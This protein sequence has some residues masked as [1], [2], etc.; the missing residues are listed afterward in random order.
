QDERTIY[1]LQDGVHRFRYHAQ[2][3]HLLGC[4]CSVCAKACAS[5]PRSDARALHEPA[6]DRLQFELP[7]FLLASI[8]DFLLALSAHRTP[9]VGVPN[10]PLRH[11]FA[12]L[13]TCALLRRLWRAQVAKGL[14]LVVAHLSSPC[15]DSRS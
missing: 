3:V 12:V 5:K 4:V 10:H 14:G 13:T 1:T 7:L 8:G 11:V 6:A 2:I 15:S 9:S